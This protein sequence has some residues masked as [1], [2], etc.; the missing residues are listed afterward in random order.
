MLIFSFVILPGARAQ[1]T[2][3]P[4]LPAYCEDVPITFSYDGNGSAIISWVTIGGDPA[5]TSDSVFTITYGTAGTW[6]IVLLVLEDPFL[7]IDLITIV[8]QPES[9]TLNTMSPAGSP[10]EGEYVSATF[11]PGTGGVECT[12]EYQFSFLI[13]A[14]WFGPFPYYE[15][16]EL[17]TGGMDEIL[18][19]ARRSGCNPL[20]GCTSSAWTEL[21]RWIVTNDA[22][23]PTITS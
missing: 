18:I 10:C 22:E 23:K 16:T 1:I 19:E 14:A 21:A 2:Y 11:N 3:D 7:V 13:G 6:P 8:E 15:G 17:P 20:A 12:D 4:D 9:P 5:T